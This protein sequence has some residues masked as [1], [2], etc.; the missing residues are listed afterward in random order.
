VS[1]FAL[2][3]LAVVA[4]CFYTD[5]VNQR[6]SLDIHRRNEGPYFRGDMTK[7]IELSAVSS[8]PEGHNVTFH[9]RAYACTRQNACDRAPYFELSEPFVDIDVPPARFDVADPLLGV[10]VRLEGKDDF[11]AVARPVQELW[12]DVDNFAPQLKLEAY[13]EFGFVVT[14]PVEVYLEVSDADD[15]PEAP[16]VTWKVYSPSNQ[17]D[18]DFVDYPAA[19]GPTG[20]KA[21][22]KLLTP[23]GVGKYMVEASATDSIAP[24]PS[25]KSVDVTVI[26]DKPPCLRTLSPLVAIAPAA[27]PI[28][29]PTLFQVHVVADDLD[30]Y[31]AVNDGLRGTTKFT[32][33]L[34]APGGSRQ[35]LTGVTGN[36]VSVNPASYQPGDVLE[37]R[38]EIADRTNTAITCADASATCSVIADNSCLQRQ[39]WRVEVR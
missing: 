30:P 34:L 26:D 24:L 37:L 11:G 19:P 18:Y 36:R 22:G 7:Q 14:A 29:D 21:Y 5:V 28:T 12:I 32:W 23:R 13:S 25:V 9:W 2:I 33:S 20:T 27:L 1:R 17:P 35:V 15:G 4:G 16:Q 39:T 8:D 6:P 3:G 10:L 31:P 38:V